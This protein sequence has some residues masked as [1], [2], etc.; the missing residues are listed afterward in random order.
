MSRL[1]K[2]WQSMPALPLEGS[3]QLTSIRFRFAPKIK[4]LINPKAA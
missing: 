1:R 4:T 2:G 3:G